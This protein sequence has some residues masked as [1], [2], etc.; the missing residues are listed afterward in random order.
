[1][2]KWHAI[3]DFWSRFGLNAYDENSVPTG[4]HSPSTPYITY[5]VITDNLNHS[6][7]LSGSLWYRSTSWEDIERKASEIA[8]YLGVGG[9]TIKI[10]DGYVWITRGQPFAQRMPD[11]DDMIKRIYINI[12]VEYL[13]TY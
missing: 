9:V 3:Q 1:M 11:N 12:Q 4:K 5:N 7:Q 8:E 2:N 13:T 6:V 10:D